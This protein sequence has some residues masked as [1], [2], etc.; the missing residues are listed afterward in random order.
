M[1]DKPTIS[2]LKD[3]NGPYSICINRNDKKM[4]A[5]D[6]YIA[7][8]DKKTGLITRAGGNSKE[9]PVRSPSPEELKIHVGDGSNLDELCKF[10]SKSCMRITL[11]GIEECNHNLLRKF[12]DLTKDIGSE[13][14]VEIKKVL[15]KDILS[16]LSKRVYVAFIDS[17]LHKNTSGL[18]KEMNALGMRVGFIVEVSG[19]SPMAGSVV[20]AA[21]YCAESGFLVVV[22]P[23]LAYFGNVL[24]CSRHDIRDAFVGIPDRIGKCRIGMSCIVAGKVQSC[25]AGRH[26]AYIDKD[27]MVYPCEYACKE[28]PETGTQVSSGIEAWWDSV[29]MDEWGKTCVS[30][31][32]F[33]KGKGD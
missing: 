9:N 29:A 19:S 13:I 22:R 27:M 14:I 25:G 10:I 5:S 1:T 26:S 3:K 32:P 30:C 28:R 6:R 31:C 4:V 23:D 8:L 33:L 17:T 21:R 2:F 15:S 12:L 24:E 20:Y 7:V 11:I 18:A 16:V